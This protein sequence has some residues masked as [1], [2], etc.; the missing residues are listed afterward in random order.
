MAIPIE[1][2]ARPVWP[3]ALLVL[4][5]LFSLYQASGSSG[6]IPDACHHLA[7]WLAAAAAAQYEPAGQ[8][9][10]TGSGGF[11]GCYAERVCAAL[12]GCAGLV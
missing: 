6:D 4:F 5:V 12:R 1:L 7:R 10:D 2:P 11:W 8:M 3:R 9:P